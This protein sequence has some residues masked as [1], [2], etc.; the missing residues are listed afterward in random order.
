MAR[1]R[2]SI[3]LIVIS[4]LAAL[5]L[6]PGQAYAAK[7]DILDKGKKA[8][9]ERQAA[10]QRAAALGLKP[11]VAGV[12][13]FKAATPLPGPEGPGGIPHYFG[14]Y[15]NWAYSPL[16]TRGIASV[17]PVTPGTGYTNPVVTISDIYGTGTA[18]AT[19]TL[20]A[21]GGIATITVDPGSAG[22]HV[23]FVTI[24]DP[25]GTGATATATLDTTV[26]GGLV[27]FV[28][29]LPLLGPSGA[30]NLGQYISVAAKEPAGQETYPGSDYYEIGLVEFYEK[31]HTSLPPTLQR[32]YVQLATAKVPGSFPL[33]YLD[34]SP[35]NYPGTTTQITAVEAPHFLGPTIV[36][37]SNKAVRIKFYN[38]LPVGLPDATG[39]R[40][41][42]LFLP[43]DE[44]TMGSGIGPAG[45][46][47]AGSAYTQNRAAVHLHGNNTVW[48]SDGT[49]HQWITPANEST[50]Y[51]QGVS[52]RNVPDMDPPASTPPPTGRSRSTTPTP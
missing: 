8:Q 10:S 13:A 37:T 24:T 35:I 32:G 12:T 30:N 14:P 15:A 45:P 31:M 2:F 44:T 21:G 48:I 50:P 18:T 5:A 25:T 51:P 43:V 40:P 47:V 42:D 4:A 6:A 9:A 33:T 39:R 49:P 41:G 16:P 27:K 20:D 36:G 28:D 3:S 52:V 11:G 19:A 38:L 29:R 26:T 22:F 1:R 17:T 46:G 34:G 23:P 7:K